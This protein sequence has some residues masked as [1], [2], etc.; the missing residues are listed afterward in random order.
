M[1]TP[2]G[3]AGGCT[4]SRFGLRLSRLAVQRRTYAASWDINAPAVNAPARVPVR[5]GY[6]LDAGIAVTGPA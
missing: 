4:A 2:I 6:T 1:A 5:N 3:T